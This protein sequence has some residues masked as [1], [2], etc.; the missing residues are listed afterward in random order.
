MRALPP[1]ETPSGVEPAAGEDEPR[2]TML[3]SCP[4]PA[5]DSSPG[6]AAD[7]GLRVRLAADPP[8]LDPLDES[9][10][11]TAQVL[12]GLVHEPLLVCGGRPPSG[13]S[14]AVDASGRRAPEPTPGLASRWQLSPGG[15]VI[16]LQLRPGALFHD[17]HAVTSTDVRATL[18]TVWHGSGRMPQARA[19]LAD[20]AAIELSGAD[21]LRLRLKRAAPIVLRALCDVPIVPAGWLSSRRPG[22]PARDPVGSGP[23]RFV[24]WQKGKSLR[25]ARAARPGLPPAPLAEIV[26][27]VE[28]DTGRALGQL[29]RGGLDLIPRLDGV[30]FPDQVRPA[31][32]GP[33][34]DLLGL[35][36]ERTTFLAV[37]HRKP[38]LSVPVFRRALSLLWD[39]AGLAEE[40][41]RGLATPIAVP[42]FA[43]LPAPPFDPAL[44]AQLLREAALV[45]PA[46]LLKGR[47]VAIQHRLTLIHSGGR[48]ATAELR[49]LA[50]RLRRLGILLELIALEPGPLA[51]RLRTGQF[52]LALLSWTSR[53]FEDPRPRF[54]SGGPF[55][56]GG[57]RSP[58]LDALLEEM[59]ALDGPNTRPDLD[60]RLGLLMAEELPAIFLY[61]HTD[62]ALAATRVRGLCNDGGRLDFSRAG[63][64]P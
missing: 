10:E 32:L 45:A 31:A 28:T 36:T 60:R 2:M 3:P 9:S 63:F 54:A 43:D 24:S 17:G 14:G 5:N 64:A 46:P 47:P 39:R 59:R 16:T 12:W 30:H 33:G 55:N 40:I 34:L 21:A 8:H 44:A 6:A 22:A 56:F 48:I 41:H 38:P 62:L 26:F 57:F 52:D 7:A 51:E 49:R 50:E 42:P 18:E 11:V 25:L 20:L 4:A 27:S 1:G 19:A 23:Y 13:G 15:D 37:N 58:R 61:R 35:A 29:R 53:P